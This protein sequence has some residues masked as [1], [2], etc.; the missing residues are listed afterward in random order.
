MTRRRYQRRQGGDGGEG[1]DKEVT[2][3][4]VVIGATLMKYLPSKKKP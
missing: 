4:E 3:I 1:G 2:A